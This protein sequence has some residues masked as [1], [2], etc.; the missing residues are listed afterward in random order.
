MR[1]SPRYRY[2]AGLVIFIL[3]LFVSF[4][5]L[6]SGVIG[7]VIY[8][9]EGNLIYVGNPKVG[10][11]IIIALLV[12]GFL[13]D[14]APSI[15]IAFLGYFIKATNMRAVKNSKKAR[16]KLKDKKDVEGFIR[17]L[18]SRREGRVKEAT[19]LKIFEQD[20][21]KIILSEEDDPKIVRKY[22][23]SM[24]RY[25]KESPKYLFLSIFLMIATNLGMALTCVLMSKGLGT[26][27]MMD[28]TKRYLTEKKART[29][30]DWVQQ[31]GECCGE[32]VFT[33]W[34]G[35]K[36]CMETKERP[37]T[38]YNL[39]NFNICPPE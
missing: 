4:L 33:E 12:E 17:L 23:C 21:S 39:E 10:P 1:K 7:I 29:A 38:E 9:T 6:A 18:K 22:R 34:F 2:Y 24:E 36:W 31:K 27:G 8:C 30:L 26:V 25:V 16:A 37:P 35:I 3:G 5:S 28:V 19:D 13:L 32:Q 15:G 20:F 11:G 14:L